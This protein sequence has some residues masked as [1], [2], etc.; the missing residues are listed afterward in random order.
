MIVLRKVSELKKEH[1]VEMAAYY[2]RSKFLNL[3]QSI[4]LIY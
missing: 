1:A 4:W 3:T 2:I